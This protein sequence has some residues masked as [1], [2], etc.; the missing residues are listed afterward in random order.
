M[1]RQYCF[2]AGRARLCAGNALYF[3][4]PA[5]TGDVGKGCVEPFGGKLEFR[6]VKGNL[7][8]WNSTFSE[9]RI[10]SVVFGR[11]GAPRRPEQNLCG[12]VVRKNLACWN[13]SFSESRIPVSIGRRAATE[14]LFS[15]DHEARRVQ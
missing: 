7:R 6:V 12:V 9:I 13:F 14:F 15:P 5:D 2:V 11:A 3:A 1:I 4:H 10:P 8:W